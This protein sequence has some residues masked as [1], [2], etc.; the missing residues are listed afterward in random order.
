M[1][2]Q[3]ARNVII[4]TKLVH[5]WIAPYLVTSVNDVN[6]WIN[7]IGGLKGL[8]EIV[9]L[10]NLKKYSGPSV[11]PEDAQCSEQDVQAD[12][13]QETATGII[14]ANKQEDQQP[15]TGQA[16]TSHAV[17]KRRNVNDGV[18]VRKATS[19]LE[20]HFRP[21]SNVWMTWS[22]WHLCRNPSIRKWVNSS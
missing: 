18:K 19:G 5:H 10:N 14:P 9:H 15:P 3:V 4:F 16:K 20:H 7:P 22:Q 17:W 8:P 1:S 6:A 2:L 21:I 13:Q 11:I 12:D